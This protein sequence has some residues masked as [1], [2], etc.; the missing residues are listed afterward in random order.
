M[1]FFD[2]VKDFANDAANALND[3]AKDVSANAKEF[4][5]KSKLKRAIKNEEAKI[6]SIYAT[7]GEKFAGEGGVQAIVTKAFNDI[8]NAATNYYNE[9]EKIK[10]AS[11]GAFGKLENVDEITKNIG[12]ITTATEELGK[13][14]KTVLTS[15]TRHIVSNELISRSALKLSSAEI[16][17]TST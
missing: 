15:V 10:T 13:Q 16:S 8:K 9:L 12:S 11:D 7:M 4:S 17:S 3:A 6:N 1:A 5:D 14:W 2:K